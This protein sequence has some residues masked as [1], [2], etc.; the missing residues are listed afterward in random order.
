MTTM[1]SRVALGAHW[2]SDVIF[3]LDARLS[4]DTNR[5]HYRK[6]AFRTKILAVLSTGNYAN[7]DV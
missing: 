3:R 5:N 6:P 7:A 4:C 2:T 1:V